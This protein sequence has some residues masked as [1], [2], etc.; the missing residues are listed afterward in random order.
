MPK[1]KGRAVTRSIVAAMV[2][3]TVFV[4]PWGVETAMAGDKTGRNISLDQQSIS[5]MTPSELTA[6]IDRVGTEWDRTAVTIASPGG[7]VTSTLADLGVTLDTAQVQRDATRLGSTAFP[8]SLLEWWSSWLTARTVPLTFRSDET[9]APKN[10]DEL[11]RL[12]HS[13]PVEAKLSSSTAGIVLVAATPGTTI[14]PLEAHRK[15]LHAA[16]AGQ[17]PIAIEVGTVPLAPRFNATDAAKLLDDATSLTDRR[18]AIHVGD[19]SVTVDATH[20]RTWLTSGIRAD[21]SGFEVGLD[22]KKIEADV[23][24]L[25]GTLG[26]GP[27]QLSWNISPEGKAEIV[28]GK[29][30]TRCCAAGSAERVIAA[31]RSR[32]SRVD[33]DFTP[34]KPDHDRAWAEQ[35]GITEQIGTFTTPHAC[36]ENRVNNIHL[37]ADAM[38][39]K[40]IEPGQT[41]S[42]NEAVGQR[43]K[44]KGFLEAHAIVDGK[45]VDN[46]GGGVSQFAATTFNAAFFG[47]LDIVEYQMHTIKIDRYPFG[48]EA[49][50][51]WEKPDLKIRNNT[52]YGVLVWPTYTDTSLTVALYSTPFAKGEQTNQTLTE[53]KPTDKAADYLCTRVVTERT[54]TF[55]ADDKKTTDTF[56]GLYQPDEGK[57]C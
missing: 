38:R 17:R 25:I 5:R 41:L 35:F 53:V 11:E 6:S 19:K 42:L 12:N 55:L 46:V 8:Q 18:L 44:E 56:V 37:F 15:A 36:C 27:V 43:T 7:L 39:G 33:L 9:V 40:I 51:S 49:T 34:V 54:R 20:F 24:R 2:M 3:L 28:E 14:D 52:P 16:R 31:L 30:G 47:G 32:A 45:Y 21:G 23:P 4:A 57:R 10:L 22:Q 1:R 50:I 29:D 48:R 26:A 13:A